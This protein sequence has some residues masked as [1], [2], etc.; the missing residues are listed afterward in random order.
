MNAVDPLAGKIG[1]RRKVLFCGEPARLE[2]SHLAR[3]CRC[4]RSR[5]AANNPT[6]RGIMTQPFCV[7]HVLIPCKPPKHGLPQQT[8]ESMS[9]VPAS[10][11]VGEYIAGNCS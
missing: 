6:H 7:V 10:A 8:D 9:A 5:L 11:C 1:E 4:P 2:A 3:R